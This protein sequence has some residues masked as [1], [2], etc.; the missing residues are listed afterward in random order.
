MW[1]LVPALI[2]L[3]FGL[4]FIG[5]TTSPDEDIEEAMMW[6]LIGSVVWP[7]TLAMLAIMALFH[8]PV[9]LG[10]LIRKICT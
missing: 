5:A 3:F 10:R 4:V 7:L 1:Y 2:C 6:I 8:I 9:G